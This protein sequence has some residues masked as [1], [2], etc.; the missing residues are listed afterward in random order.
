MKNY[1]LA[2]KSL[3]FGETNRGKKVYRLTSKKLQNT[4][5]TA[6]SIPSLESYQLSSPALAG[7]GK[8]VANL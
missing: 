3:F 8:L 5:D 4:F 2:L 7:E 1:N 6:L